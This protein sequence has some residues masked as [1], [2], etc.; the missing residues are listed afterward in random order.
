M[1]NQSRVLLCAGLCWLLAGVAIAQIHDP[2]A[3]EA[4]PTTADK[5]IAPTLDGLGTAQMV[6]TT[7]S[8]ESQRFFNQGLRLTYGFNHSEALRAFKEAVRLDP[9]NAMAYWGWALVLGP[10]LNLPMQKEVKEQAWEA[11]QK[12]VAL[13]EGVTGEERAYIDA[14]SVRYSDDDEADRKELDRV[15]EHAMTKLSETYPDDDNAAT[16]R[17]ASLMNLSPWAYWNKD[18]SPRENTKVILATLKQVIERNPKHIGAIHYYIH[19]VEATHPQRAEAAADALAGL[20]PNAGHLVHMPAHIYMRV[21]RYQDSYETNVKAVEADEGYITSCQAQGI[22]PLGYYPHNIHFMVW[23]AMFEGRSSESLKLARKVASKIPDHIDEK[24]WGAYELFRSQPF[25]AMVRFGMWDEV[26]AEPRPVE[27]S[28]F[29]TGIWH[30]ARA[31]A[32]LHTGDAG[33]GKKELKGLMRIRDGLED[34]NRRRREYRTL[35][36]IAAEIVQAE[37]SAKRSRYTD[38]IARL[39]RAVRLEDSLTY[40][41]P[42]SWYFP[43]RHVLG[44]VL[45]EAGRPVEAEVV[46]W[47]DLRKNPNNGWALFGLEQSLRAQQMDEEA[48]AAAERFTRAW[49]RADTK[50][51]TTRF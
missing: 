28:K 24:N 27:K 15:Y 49:D 17:A 34:K 37:I 35:L 36:T 11:M 43:V 31:L 26:L 25:Y 19:A 47:E 32:Y 33:R 18:G 20:A 46:Y 22:Y 16:L 6:V 45:I 3:V 38:A 4:D 12:A 39:D 41:E 50:L 23:S 44:A 14:L 10:N 9:K 29:M 1:T 48:D 5:P 42:P 21:G 30:Y 13:R 7:T 8:P 51:T 2:R 40:T